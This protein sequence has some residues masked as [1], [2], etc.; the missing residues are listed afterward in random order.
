MA[1]LV[2]RSMGESAAVR[3][4]I[5][6]AFAQ[7]A[8]RAQH[9][10]AGEVLHGVP[11]AGPTIAPLPIETPG[12]TTERAAHLNRNVDSQ[13]SLLRPA[14]VPQA[15]LMEAG[16]SLVPHEEK[17]ADSPI[18]RVTA[19]EAKEAVAPKSNPL[20]E[21]ETKNSRIIEETGEHSRTKAAPGSVFQAVVIRQETKETLRVADQS[22]EHALARS[23]VPELRPAVRKTEQPLESPRRRPAA[24]PPAIQ[25]TIGR[26][27]VRASIGAPKSTEKKMPAGAMSLEEYQRLR[28]RR[29]SG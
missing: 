26:I 7:R 18:A 1:R 15:N 23:A 5:A 11:E 10:P 29:G 21:G 14:K 16:S 8:E 13:A 3:P 9:G 6:P 17:A 24:E 22:E 2:A 28:S 19:A 4:R 12:V 20:P 27:E 25:V